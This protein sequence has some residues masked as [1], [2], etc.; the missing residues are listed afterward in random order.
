VPG[1]AVELEL[2]FEAQ[3]P[4]VLAR[5]GWSGGYHL[6]G[7]WFP[8]LGVFEPTGRGGRPSAGWNCHQF[9][10]TSEF[11]AD[12]ARYRV[13]M[14]VPEDFVLGA[15]GIELE[16]RELAE[17][18]A[19]KTT[20]TY[21]AD[22]VH[23]FAWCAAPASLME[24]VEADFEPARD[25]PL[26]WLDR[27]VRLLGLSAAELELPPM[28]IRL[29]RP[30][31]QEGMTARM[32]RGVRLAV[33][34]YGLFYG[35]YPYPQ[36]TVVAPPPGAEESG[37]MEYPTFITSL[38][39]RLLQYPPLSWF[40]INEV[41]TVHEFGH[42]YFQGILASN[43]F[44]QAWLDEGLNTYAETSCLTA[45]RDDG[46]IPEVKL[47]FGWTGERAGWATRET[48]LHIDRAS[49]EYRSRSDYALASYTKT[50]LVIKTL[51]GLLGEELFA[52][53]MRRYATE[54]RFR[55]PTGADLEASISE[56]SGQDLSW[57]FDQALASDDMVDWAVAR[58]RHQR[59]SRDEGLRWDGAQWVPSSES[60]ESSAASP[61]PD[62]GESW[63]IEVDVLR[64]G[65]FVGPV[66]VLLV[67][68]DGREERR[69]WDGATRWRRFEMTSAARLEAVVVDPNGIWA[70]EGERLDNYWR[71]EPEV[72]AGRQRMWWAVALVR[73]VARVLVPWS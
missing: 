7:Q 52:R 67:F 63:M 49:W 30:R 25:V 15:T 27:A 28:H 71:A 51:E 14:T 41:V 17:G 34:W 43:E 1:A 53:A 50:A 60:V 46:L 44:E 29:L 21:T 68:A 65:E 37:G 4:K 24:V 69:T 62:A 33:A 55:H 40:A 72:G 8:K 19:R 23:D 16:R 6:V 12:F 42:Q 61:A 56:T 64:Q 2:R 5:T 57:F 54:W 47:V 13:Q 45:I 18:A 9:H 66:E 3:L 70:L 11:Y 32:L 48:P 36:L 31:T 73:A 58:V 39:S 35:P 26:A 20:Y 10:P 59:R 38:S 22:R